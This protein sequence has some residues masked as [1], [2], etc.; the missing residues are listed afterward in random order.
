M[1][2]WHHK[3]IKLN[4]ALALITTNNRVVITVCESQIE[5]ESLSSPR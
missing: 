4:E 1:R 3:V 5:F 2:D